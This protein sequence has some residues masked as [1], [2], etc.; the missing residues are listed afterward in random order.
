MRKGKSSFLRTPKSKPDTEQETQKFV[1][2]NSEKKNDAES[3]K[4]KFVKTNFKKK[5]DTE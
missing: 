3:E 1:K 2:T 5:N 4:Q